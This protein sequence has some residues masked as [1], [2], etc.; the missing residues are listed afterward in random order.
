VGRETIMVRFMRWVLL[1]AMIVG[2]AASAEAGKGNQG[3]KK[4]AKSPEKR[5]AK[6]D[7]DY[8]G[9]LSLDEFIGKRSNDEKAKATKRFSKLD[10]NSDHFL[11]LD[12]LKSAAKGSKGGN[13]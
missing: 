7:R 9:K 3:G 8:D 2:N 12:E 6:A 4:G 5:F 10:K 11:T 1:G 13:S